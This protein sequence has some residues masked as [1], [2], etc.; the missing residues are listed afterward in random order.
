MFKRKYAFLVI[1]TAMAMVFPAAAFSV[2][3]TD[4][5]AILQELSIFIDKSPD[6][7][8]NVIFQMGDDYS[9]Q[10]KVDEAI[11]LYEKG[12]KVLPDDE[13]LMNRLA[14]Q[15][16]QKKDYKKA[17]DIYKR[18]TELNPE[19]VWYF[20]MLSDAYR[21][22]GDKVKA[23][24]LWEGLLK[25][26]NK[27]E[28]FI[29][30]ANF[31]SGENDAEKA[32]AAVKK[33]VELAP[34]NMGYQQALEGFYMR[35]ENFSGAEAI[36]NK[37]L[38]GSKDQW[39]R[40]WADSELINVYQRQNRLGALAENFEKALAQAPKD[41]NQY[42]RLAEL[43]QRNNERDRAIAVYEKAIAA[44]I[45]DRDINNRL[46]DLYES[47][48]NTDKA[49]AQ[50]KKIIAGAPQDNY[51]YERLANLLGRLDKKDDAKKAWG[52][53]LSKTQNDASAFSR[54]ADKLNE[55]GDVDGAVAQY[56]KAQSIDAKNL[57]YTIR[58]SDIFIAKG[59]FD[60]AKKELNN[61][62]AGTKDAWMK[63]EAERR[64]KDIDAKAK[65]VVAVPAKEAKPAKKKKGLFSR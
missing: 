57:W 50:I 27:P 65:E 19:N 14:N 42:R 47:A 21:S 35:S 37:I 17:I 34:D 40:D 1:F 22:A 58:I 23:A 62:I 45:D 63:Q 44:G 59:N 53:F 8:R 6:I 20:N 5:D 9:R 7:L 10:N 4:K 11:A 25:T 49:E 30:A 46:L 64:I 12:L 36:C 61:I 39:A 33:A 3:K 52:D 26:S 16:N 24:G 48:N 38:A 15:Y 29:Q 51:L 41:I 31:Y 28:V 56:R 18:M 32:M 54:Y 55:W 60:S 2:G 13:D 43:Y